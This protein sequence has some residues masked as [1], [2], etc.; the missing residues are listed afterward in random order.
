MLRKRCEQN[1][2]ARAKI[3]AETLRERAEEQSIGIASPR[4]ES[5]RNGYAWFRTVKL[6]KGSVSSA[7]AWNGIAVRRTGNEQI[8]AEPRW[9]S[10]AL[11]SKGIAQHSAGMDT[12]SDARAQQGN[13]PDEIRKGYELK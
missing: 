12:S 6:R 13:S 11:H 9:P 8:H 2:D 10:A 4:L 3:S 5:R 7:W 1:D